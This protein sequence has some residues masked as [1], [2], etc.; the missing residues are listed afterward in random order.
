MFAKFQFSHIRRA[1][2]LVII[3]ISSLA[4]GLPTTA[5]EIAPLPVLSSIAGAIAPDTIQVRGEG[6]TAG[7]EVFIAIHDPWGE[8]SYETRWTTASKPTMD[9][10]GHDD[11]ALGFRPGGLVFESFANLCG[12]QVMVRAYDQATRSWSNVVDIESAC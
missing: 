9:M 2:L 11:P 3:A 4:P 8:R 5:Q 10:L 12:Q 6:F 1:V 7:G